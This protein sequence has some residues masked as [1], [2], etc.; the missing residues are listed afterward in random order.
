MRKNQGWTLLAFMPQ[1][2]IGCAR[3]RVVVTGS[4]TLENLHLC[5]DEIA[6][7]DRGGG[8]SD[9]AWAWKGGQMKNYAVLFCA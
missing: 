1:A 9:A 8:S 4:F 7:G 3:L 5:R 6:A 2:Q